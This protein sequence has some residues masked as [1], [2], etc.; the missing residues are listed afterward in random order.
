MGGVTVEDFAIPYPAVPSN[1]L[2]SVN[3]RAV[4]K[5]TQILR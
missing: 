5:P 2:S 3:I 4:C 1:C